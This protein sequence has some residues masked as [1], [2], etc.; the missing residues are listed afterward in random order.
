M[1][2]DPQNVDCR[3]APNGT[4]LKLAISPEGGEITGKTGGMTR[5]QAAPI[6]TPALGRFP[7]DMHPRWGT[8]WML[9]RTLAASPNSG[10]R[11]FECISLQRRESVS[12]PHPLSKIE[13]PGS[14]RGC[15]AGLATEAAQCSPPVKRAT[16]P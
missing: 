8:D 16:I 10:N 2:D 3:S 7:Y 14:S 11:K 4:P 1:I 5:S 9:K 13:S 6:K 12:L 15:A